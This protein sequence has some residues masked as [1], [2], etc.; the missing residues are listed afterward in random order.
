MSNIVL[1]AIKLVDREV[2]V[3]ISKRLVSSPIMAAEV[4]FGFKPAV[5]AFYFHGLPLL[6]SGL[7]FRKSS[8]FPIV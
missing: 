8:D 4:A 2:R 3:K 6:F 5:G 7:R 1:I